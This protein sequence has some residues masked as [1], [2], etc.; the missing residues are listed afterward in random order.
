LGAGIN[1]KGELTDLGRFEQTHVEADR[2]AF[3]T[4]DLRNV[5]KTAP[6]MHDGSLKTLKDVVD[7][8]DGGGTSNPNRDPEIKELKLSEKEREDLVA[9]LESL[10]GKVKDVGR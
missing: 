4:P 8:Y 7:F 1:S 2:G 3:R 6:Y 10:T 9:F 5:A